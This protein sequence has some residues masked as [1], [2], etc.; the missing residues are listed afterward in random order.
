MGWAV[1]TIVPEGVPNPI[2]QDPEA[3]LSWAVRNSDVFTWVAGGSFALL[4]N[5]AQ[6]RKWLPPTSGLVPF[7]VVALFFSIPF[8]IAARIP[9]KRWNR[10]IDWY[11]E[12]HPL[13]RIALGVPITVFALAYVALMFSG[14]WLV[15]N[16]QEERI[17]R[18]VTVPVTSAAVSATSGSSASDTPNPEV[19]L[20]TAAQLLEARNSALEAQNKQ[21]QIQID[22]VLEELKQLRAQ[23]ATTP[24]SAGPRPAGSGASSAATPATPPT[25]TELVRPTLPPV[26]TNTCVTGRT[27]FN[28]EPLEKAL[29]EAFRLRQ[30][31]VA[32]RGDEISERAM[33]NFGN[34]TLKSNLENFVGV[35]CVA[36]FERVVPLMS[37][38]DQIPADFPA[39]RIPSLQRFDAQLAHVQQIIAALRLPTN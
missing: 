7:L 12:R 11:G 27:G 16:Y 14:F 21:Q 39:D 28:L 6:E 10:L 25:P 23:R 13:E 22:Q 36:P 30:D 3:P 5:F 8:L 35:A 33:T 19:Q 26:T 34:S 32:N 24:P 17:A 37:T 15:Q 20:Y 2:V 9:R 18:I 29:T 1:E 31:Y 38:P 4:C